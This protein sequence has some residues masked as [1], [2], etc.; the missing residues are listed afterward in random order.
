MH[1]A[2]QDI[3]FSALVTAQPHSWGE[4]KVQIVVPLPYF[5][6]LFQAPLDLF[7]SLHKVLY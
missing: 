5:H 2:S 7:V 1:V 6:A 4:I 3:A